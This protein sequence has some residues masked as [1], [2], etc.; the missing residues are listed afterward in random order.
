MAEWRYDKGENRHK[1]SG[2]HSDAR[3]VFKQGVW[4]GK[5]PKSFSL[6]IAGELLSEGVPEYLDRAPDKPYRLWNYHDG[7]I[8]VAYSQDRGQT[9]HGFPN[10]HPKRE[11]PRRI[12]RELEKRAS[13][14]GEEQRIKEWLKKRW[15]KSE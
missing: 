8:Y 4:V 5:C 7:A 6:K 15:D 1:H 9:W 12:L 10:G 13:E 14:R 11:P 2:S 3:M